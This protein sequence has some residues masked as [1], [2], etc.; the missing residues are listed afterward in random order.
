MAQFIRVTDWHF[1]S[2]IDRVRSLVERAWKLSKVHPKN[3]VRSATGGD[4]VWVKWR[5]WRTARTFSP[6]FGIA[7]SKSGRTSR[8]SKPSS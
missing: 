8:R 4:C 5:N 7:M 1:V 3:G 2:P 6:F